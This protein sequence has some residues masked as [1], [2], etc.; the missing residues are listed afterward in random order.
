MKTKTKIVN[1]IAGP[2]V[3]KSTT[4]S[5]LF[6]KLKAAKVSCELIF[7]VAK[8]ATW[9][10][11]HKLLQNQ[12]YI[13][14]EQFRRQWRLINKVEYVITDSPLLLSAVYFEQFVQQSDVGFTLSYVELVKDFYNETFKQ[15][16][17]VN[18]MLPRVKA[19]DPNGR[20]QNLKEAIELDRLITLNAL[21]NNVSLIH[22]KAQDNLAIAEE[23]ASD[24]IAG[25]YTNVA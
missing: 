24:I 11:H 7:E 19:Y 22:P 8:E 18:I 1:M 21:N 12:H 5:A 10:E 17:N 20:N 14:A 2:G 25:V 15:F 9:E 4:A 6:A 3:G 16:N 13:F 23:I